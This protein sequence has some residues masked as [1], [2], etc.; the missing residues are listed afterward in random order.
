MSKILNVIMK[1]FR[2]NFLHPFTLFH[3]FRSFLSNTT[4]F[5]SYTTHFTRPLEVET[6]TFPILKKTLA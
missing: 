5:T 1:Q 3:R 6:L 4:D 2:N